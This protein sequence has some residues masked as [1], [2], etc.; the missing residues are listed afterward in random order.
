[1]VATQLLVVHFGGQSHVELV[2][3][4]VHLLLFLLLQ[5]GILLVHVPRAVALD[6]LLGEH[7]PAGLRLLGRQR[8]R[9]LSPQIV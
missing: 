2:G 5:L 6:L 7:V 4:R 1:M 8:N 9:L 3:H